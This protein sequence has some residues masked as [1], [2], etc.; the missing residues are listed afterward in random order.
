MTEEIPYDEFEKDVYAEMRRLEQYEQT[1]HPKMEVR[2]Q[3]MEV[4]IQQREQEGDLPG[5]EWLNHP[6]YHIFVIYDTT[7][8]LEGGQVNYEEFAQNRR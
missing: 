4:R 5:H 2:I 6:I 7:I 3:Q 1:M 8:S